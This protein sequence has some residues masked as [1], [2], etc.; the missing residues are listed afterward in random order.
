ML[1]ENHKSS[2][3]CADA[4]LNVCIIQGVDLARVL[5]IS[6]GTRG[7]PLEISV[8]LAGVQIFMF[9]SFGE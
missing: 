6:F 3:R 8:F 4:I 9:K 2:H 1:S 7:S 5:K